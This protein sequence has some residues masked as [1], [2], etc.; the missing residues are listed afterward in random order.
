MAENVRAITRWYIKCIGTIKR[1]GKPPGIWQS[2]S[3]DGFSRI[4]CFSSYFLSSDFVECAEIDDDNMK[5][6]PESY[7][8]DETYCPETRLCQKT[9]FS[10]TTCD[11]SDLIM[12]K[13]NTNITKYDYFGPFNCTYDDL[14]CLTLKS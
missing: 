13:T 1:Y 7:P 2:D 8:M 4:A 10:V 6:I 9:D 5:T 12:M 11:F 3:S 14:T